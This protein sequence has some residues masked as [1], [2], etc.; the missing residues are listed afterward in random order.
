MKIKESELSQANEM[1]KSA[2]KKIQNARQHVEDLE[3][4]KEELH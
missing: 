2:N 3:R 1:A 4:E